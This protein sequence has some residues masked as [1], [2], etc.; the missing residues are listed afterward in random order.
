MGNTIPLHIASG[1]RGRRNT[2][3][4]LGTRI[5]SSTTGAET[6]ISGASLGPVAKVAQVERPSTRGDSALERG[7]LRS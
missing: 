3:Y 5:V 7:L 1:A 2:A 6:V 4:G